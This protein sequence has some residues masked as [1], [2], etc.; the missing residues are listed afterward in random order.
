MVCCPLRFAVSSALWIASWALMVN[1]S[2]VIFVSP[3]CASS[4][5][6]VAPREVLHVFYY[7]FLPND[8][9]NLYPICKYDNTAQIDDNL[10]PWKT[11]INDKQYYV[12]HDLQ[13]HHHCRNDSVY[14]GSR[15]WGRYA[16]A[17]S[18]SER[19][20]KSPSA[21]SPNEL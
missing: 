15:P 2:N 10:S 9:Q 3:F 17:I 21:N 8:R 5:S 4:P 19:E 11:I 16:T 6:A 20:R 1:L 14:F 18:T 13:P 7:C 12:C